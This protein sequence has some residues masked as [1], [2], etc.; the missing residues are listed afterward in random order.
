M[1]LSGAFGAALVR[2][3]I[4]RTHDLDPLEVVPLHQ[5][6]RR[7]FSLAASLKKKKGGEIAK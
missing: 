5:R 3:F 7:N 2:S 4:G 1:L 6:M